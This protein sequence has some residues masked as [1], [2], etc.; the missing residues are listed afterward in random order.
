[1]RQAMLSATPSVIRVTRGHLRQLPQKATDHYL[2]RIVQAV[3]VVRPELPIIAVTP[4]P[5]D[6]KLYPSDRPH[7]SAVAA[8]KVWARDVGIDLIDLDPLVAPDFVNGFANPD[9]LH[10]GW[11]THECVGQALATTCAAH[12]I[13]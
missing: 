12:R 1:M 8:S 13:N 3:R 4:A 7:A 2:S 11:P 9:G 6:S 10:W 5:Y